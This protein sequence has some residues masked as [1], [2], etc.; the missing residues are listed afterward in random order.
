MINI[1]KKNLVS[2]HKSVSSHQ[3]KLKRSKSTDQILAKK[4]LKKSD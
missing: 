3:K 4:I 2:T 1:S